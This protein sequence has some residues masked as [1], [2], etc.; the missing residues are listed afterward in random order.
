MKVIL[1]DMNHDWVGIA[2]GGGS[3]STIGIE[4]LA[5]VANLAHCEVQIIHQQQGHYCNEE[6]AR[7][8]SKAD[9]V[10]FTVM[11]Y[12]YERT[13]ECIRAIKKESPKTVTVVGGA[14]PTGMPELFCDPAVDLVA[15]GEGEA[16]FKEILERVS[17]GKELTGIAGTAYFKDGSLQREVPAIR[18]ESLDNI[19]FPLRDEVAIAASRMCGC[20][21]VPLSE[22]RIT[23]ITYC[24]GCSGKCKFCV[25][26]VIWGGT[27][28]WRSAVNTVDEIEQLIEKHSVNGLQ[29]SDPTF[30][31]NPA[32]VRALCEEIIKRGVKIN[33]FVFCD[34]G[35]ANQSDDLLDMMHE[36]GCRKMGVGI[37]DPLLRIGLQKRSDNMDRVRDFIRRI[38]ERGVI[39]RGYF[40]IGHPEQR[41]A[42]FEEI[43]NFMLEEPIDEIRLSIY[44]PLPGTPSWR[45]YEYIVP[46][47][48]SILSSFDTNNLVVKG[49]YSPDE[50]QL[51]RRNIG[52][53][54]YTSPE[55]KERKESR[56]AHHG[57]CRDAYE[58]LE[59]Q[60]RANGFLD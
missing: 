59:G 1:V 18:I 5:A 53:S 32:R 54:F 20:W 45:D 23:S 2:T 38:A 50:I 16:T 39:V 29:F 13:L 44:T 52:K 30:N 60:L 22:Q 7:I 14:L 12:N 33:W 19:R 10:G 46:N 40:M 27:S 35:L 43:R 51:I 47:P 34:P 31:I 6:V 17:R 58:Y 3:Y 37:E 26:R 24:R 28:T 9:V 4:Y 48:T 56:I 25:D 15:I 11:A 57:F 55:Y 21:V 36:A 49:H 8:G 42:N 41:E